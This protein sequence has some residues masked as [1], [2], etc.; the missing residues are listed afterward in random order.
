MNTG[1]GS[2]RTGG[3][4]LRMM[5]HSTVRSKHFISIYLFFFSAHTIFTVLLK[6][7]SLFFCRKWRHAVWVPAARWVQQQRS[8]RR[9]WRCCRSCA[10]GPKQ[11]NLLQLLVSVSFIALLSLLF[12]TVAFLHVLN[13]QLQRCGQSHTLTETLNCCFMCIIWSYVSK[14]S[15]FGMTI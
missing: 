6:L 1:N 14:C 13:L 9:R 4:R 12:S 8:G 15:C 10:V 2:E 7:K 3:A 5:C 11:Q